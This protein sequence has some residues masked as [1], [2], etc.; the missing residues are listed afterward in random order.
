MVDA[1]SSTDGIATKVVLASGLMATPLWVA[2]LKDISLVASAVSVVCGA[3]I[4]IYQVF[5]II[6]R[7]KAA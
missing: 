6:N 7:N 4:G 5:R 2:V 1:I 3:I